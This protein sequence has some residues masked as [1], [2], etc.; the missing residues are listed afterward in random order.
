MT[1]SLVGENCSASCKTKDHRSW[2]ECVK[3]KNLRVGWANSA[4]GIDLTKQKKWDS[5]LQEYRDA[6]RQG[7]QPKSSKLR[8]IRQAVK[9]SNETGAAFDGTK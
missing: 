3:S 6:R 5:R 9:V 7:I 2:G 4:A 8:D 1:T